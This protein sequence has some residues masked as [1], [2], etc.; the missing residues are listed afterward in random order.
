MPSGVEGGI[1]SKW[2]LM[3]ASGKCR[4]LILPVIL[5]F[6]LLFVL[7]EGLTVGVGEERVVAKRGAKEYIEGLTKPTK[8]VKRKKIMLTNEK[9]MM[10]KKTLDLERKPEMLRRTELLTSS[11]INRGGIKKDVRT[12]QQQRT[13]NTGRDGTGEVKRDS[14]GVVA[15]KILVVSATSGRAR[16]IVPRRK[17]RKRAKREYNHLE[18]EGRRGKEEEEE[19]E[20]GEIHVMEGEERRSRKRMKREAAGN[21]Y[22]TKGKRKRKSQKEESKQ[23]MMA[24]RDKKDANKK[25]VMIDRES[26]KKIIIDTDKDKIVIKDK[27]TDKENEKREERKRNRKRNRN[28]KRG[29]GGKKDN[30]KRKNSNKDDNK[31]SR[32]KENKGGK[33][34]NKRHAVMIDNEERP[35]SIQELEAITENECSVAYLTFDEISAGYYESNIDCLVVSSRCCKIS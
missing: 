32:R 17:R 10:L 4:P 13:Q 11:T 30:K 3:S 1:N 5:F 7:L 9:K 6:L 19:E 25:D 2:L 12:Q 16:V 24:K 27:D 21:A 23:R 29:K 20:W 31:G 28:R 8:A 26:R 33:K 22:E 14:H 35:L 15:K 34:R 18:D